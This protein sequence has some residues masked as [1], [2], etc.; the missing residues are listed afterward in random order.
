MASFCDKIEINQ[1]LN[2]LNQD[3]LFQK[4]VSYLK[5][6]LINEENDLLIL[7]MSEPMN[8]QIIYKTDDGKI[9]F[10]HMTFD[11]KVKLIVKLIC[12]MTNLDPNKNHCDWSTETMPLNV[13]KETVISFINH[14]DFVTV[15]IKLEGYISIKEILGIIF[16]P[17]DSF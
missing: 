16:N 9:N 10:N 15:C 8:Y 5:N 14:I 4:L 7:K 1:Y 13:S 2:E 11:D 3:S 12:R 6:F 17:Y